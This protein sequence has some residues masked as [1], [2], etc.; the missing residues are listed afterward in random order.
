L[1]GRPVYVNNPAHIN[2]HFLLCFIA[3]TMIRI[4]QHKVLIYQE[5]ST[6]STCDWEMGLSADRIK[7][8]LADFCADPLP[9]GFFRLTKPSHDLSL[10]A[11]SLNIHCALR[12]PELK[13]IRKLKSRIDSAFI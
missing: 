1:E 4:L 10:L 8:A 11:D 7:T 5:K 6:N 13:Q 2:A 12:I 9:G 3:L